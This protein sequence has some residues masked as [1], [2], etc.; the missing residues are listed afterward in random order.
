M[1]SE[2]VITVLERCLVSSD[3]HMLEKAISLYQQLVKRGE[4]FEVPEALL[5]YVEV[6]ESPLLRI[7]LNILLRIVNYL[8]V[9][10]LLQFINSFNSSLR[11]HYRGGTEIVNLRQLFKYDR[12]QKYEIAF[13]LAL[14]QGW[15]QGVLNF[16]EKLPCEL[17]LP[18]LQQL[19]DNNVSLLAKLLHKLDMTKYNHLFNTELFKQYPKVIV[20]MMHTLA[21]QKSD[22]EMIRSLLNITNVDSAILLT[23]EIN[24]LSAVNKYFRYYLPL[25]KKIAFL[26][27][28]IKAN[29]LEVIESIIAVGYTRMVSNLIQN[30]PELF[31]RL[32][33]NLAK[34]DLEHRRRLSRL[35][36]F[37]SELTKHLPLGLLRR[38]I[39]N[40]SHRIAPERR[41]RFDSALLEYAKYSK[42]SGVKINYNDLLTITAIQGLPQLA[43]W[44]LD[45]GAR[46][47]S[48][49]LD[50]H[51]NIKST[52]VEAGASAL[53]TRMQ[54]QSDLEIAELDVKY[55]RTT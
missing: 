42:A 20:R 44:A 19:L 22:K 13:E 37:N 47:S 15:N 5:D 14:S 50:Y 1:N 4:H 6:N 29:N 23:S 34:G 25:G 3:E 48:Y 36:I 27:T 51:S 54:E 38:I 12:E 7:P 39:S 21:Q 40:Y 2:E 52:L 41:E 9:T 26:D 10:D 45:N 18:K 28:M 32:A 33:Q 24:W 55:L 49:T 35:I 31:S 46:N 30:H 53:L 43:N 17:E 16:F 8:S 11:Y